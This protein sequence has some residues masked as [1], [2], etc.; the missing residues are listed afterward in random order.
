MVYVAIFGAI[1]MQSVTHSI[2]YM[3]LYGLGTVP[4]MSAVV[5]ISNLLSIPIRSKLQQIIPIVIVC[6]GILFIIRG[7]GLDIPYLSP[8]NMNLFVSP[9]ANCH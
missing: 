3:V 1:A 2:L 8:S 7:L 4:M 6:I 5:Y 9:N